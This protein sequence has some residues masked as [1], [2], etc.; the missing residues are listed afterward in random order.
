MRGQQAH[1]FVRRVSRVMAAIVSAAILQACA[2][3]GGFHLPQ[4]DA[5]RGREAFVELKCHLCHVIDGFD[6]PAPFVAATRVRL[7]GQTPRVK[8]YGDLVTSIVNPSHRISPGYPREAVTTN[9][10]STMSLI[11]LNAVLT[12]QQLVDLTAFLQSKYEVQPPII[13][14]W[15]TYP[16]NDPNG[17]RPARRSSAE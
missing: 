6:P 7:G 10:V 3:A 17:S 2:T 8:T 11:Y 9:G 12:V 16:T 1:F 4:G 15:E 13:P 5:A 14:H